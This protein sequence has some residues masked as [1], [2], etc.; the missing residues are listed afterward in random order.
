MKLNFV[1][2]SIVSVCCPTVR[3]NVFALKFRRV[4]KQCLPKCLF[5]DTM[6]VDICKEKI[7]VFREATL[8]ANAYTSAPLDFSVCYSPGGFSAVNLNTAFV[9]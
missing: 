3:H 1:V 7:N 6:F 8:F 2:E 5:K 9:S 4:L